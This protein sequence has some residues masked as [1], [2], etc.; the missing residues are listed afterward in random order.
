M[1]M[2]EE[3]I[4]HYL[5]QLLL[6]IP[7]EK[8]SKFPGDAGAFQSIENPIIFILKGQSSKLIAQDEYFSLLFSEESRSVLSQYPQN[9]LKTTIVNYVDVI[10][11][12]FTSYFESQEV[13]ISH[14]HLIAI[15][16]LQ[17][18]IQ[19][20]F[21]GP[22]IEYNSKELFFPE[23]DESTLKL[24]SIKL[25]NLQGQIAYDLTN[26][27]LFLIISESIFEKLLGF[28][29]EFSFLGSDINTNFEEFGD[30]I[31]ILAKENEQDP[32]KASIQWWMVRALQVHLS[33]L[34]EAPSIPLTVSSVL[35]NPKVLAALIPKTQ[36]DVNIQKH[37][38]ILYVLEFARLHIHSSTEHLAIPYLVKARNY[39]ELSFLMT[40]AKAKR[41]KFQKHHNSALIILAKSKISNIYESYAINNNPENFSLGDD[42]LLEKPE[43]ESLDDLEL[44]DQ[45][46]R[47]RIRLDDDND[48]SSNQED[49]L[50]PVVSKQDEIPAELK[51]LDPNN[52][53]ALNDIDSLQLLLVL[54]ILKQTSPSNDSLI[55]QELFALVTRLIY[56]DCINTNWS[57]FS[58][59]LWERSL[60]E[61]N[62]SRTVERGILQM[63]SLVEEIGIK[64]KSRMIP[65][66]AET[67]NENDTVAIRLRFIHQLPLMPQWTMDAELAEKY[68]SLGVIKS[69]LEIYERLQMSCEAALCYAA[70][71]NEKEADAI[72]VERIK[73]H[74]EDCRAISILGDIRQDPT[75]WEEAWKLGRYAKAKAS[76]SRYHYSPPHGLKQDMNLAIQ[77]MRDC[78]TINPLNYGNWYFYGC[79]GLESGQYDLAS[80]AFTRCVSLDETSSHAWSNLASALLKLDKQRPAFNAL[81]KAIRSA[82]ENKKS[83]K[84]FENYIIVAA[85]LNEWSDVLSAT[86][87]VIEIRKNEGEVCIDL[88]I[89]EKLVELLVSTPFEDSSRLTHYQKSCIDLVCNILPQVITTSSRCWRVVARVELWRKRPWA[90]LDCHEKAYRALSQRPELESNETAWNDAVEACSDLVGAYESL[91]ELPGKHDAGDLVCSDWKYKARTSIRGL[92][93]K[94]KAMWEDSEGWNRLQDLMEDLT[95]N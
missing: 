39:S 93:S 87:E 9:D 94:G 64:I 3:V 10:L 68:M 56:S 83:W 60:L 21:T 25:L 36:A 62:K 73:S 67:N 41:T 23:T 59:A 7:D 52:Q 43:F 80:E 30:S 5:A 14:L 28:K 44:P 47:K 84:I 38:Q 95:N 91:G 13:A 82:N 48:D 16:F 18:F 65:Q 49:K 74:P 34:S 15:A 51:I 78:L 81:Q 71:D 85:Q 22:N 45:S 92:R 4:K 1:N 58:R 11:T 72:L 24:E 31:T 90:A 42:L 75:L 2:S 29:R 33:V 79:C 53:P 32:L 66:A 54:T 89:I 46:D 8:F 35:L 63:T 19:L 55:Q 77:H 50:V 86:K 57:I 20:N 69:A 6:S 88:P 12:S 17:T 26:D 70:T 27:P 40:G 76:L 61:T 37:M